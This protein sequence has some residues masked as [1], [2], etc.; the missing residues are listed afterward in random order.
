M[1]LLLR[2][3]DPTEGRI[4]IDGVDLREIDLDSWLSHIGYVPQQLEVFDGTI[5]YNLTYGLSDSQR[6]RFTDA[7]IWGTMQTL[8]IDFG[9][10][11]REGLATRIGFNGIK[12]SGGRISV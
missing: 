10:R 2:Y 11:L 5:R 8:N 3:M 9:D 7:D 4:A 6:K 12:L 1:K